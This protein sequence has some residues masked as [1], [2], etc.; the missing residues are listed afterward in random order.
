[1]RFPSKSRVKTRLFLSYAAA[2][3]FLL[4]LVFGVGYAV[5][6]D[7]TIANQLETHRIVSD[8]MFLSVAERLDRPLKF[9]IQFNLSKWVERMM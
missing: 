1:M 5:F 9:A 8:Q 7:R 6:A 2:F 3:P 4:T